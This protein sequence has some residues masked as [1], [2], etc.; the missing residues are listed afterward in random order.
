MQADRILVGLFGTG[1]LARPVM[2]LVRHSLALAGLEP[3]RCD[4]A[5]VDRNPAQPMLNGVPVLAEDAFFAAPAAAKYFNVAIAASRLRQRI[6]GACLGHGALPLAIQAP[7]ALLYDGNTIGEGAVL[8]ANTM[9][10]CNIRIGRY[11][12]LNIFSYVEHDCVIGDFVT[13]APGVKCNGNVHIGDHAFI[14]AGAILRDGMLGNPTVIGAGAV[15]G[16]GAV[17]T[18]SVPPGV[19]VVGNPARPLAKPA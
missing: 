19:T 9:V 17:V 6:V 5:F 2:P 3:A 18:R 12:H 8:C 7:G 1:G 10:T 13:F 14:G 11:F 4:I 16:M 15:V